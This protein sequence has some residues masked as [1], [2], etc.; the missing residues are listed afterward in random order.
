MK[1]RRVFNQTVLMLLG[2]LCAWTV[3][4]MDGDASVISEPTSEMQD[5][6]SGFTKQVIG[7]LPWPI[8]KIKANYVRDGHVTHR[9]DQMSITL[10]GDVRS[11]NGQVLYNMWDIVTDDKGWEFG[12]K[13]LIYNVNKLLW[14]P[15]RTDVF[16]ISQSR[17]FKAGKKVWIGNKSSTNSS[18][19]SYKTTLTYMK[20]KQYY[21]VASQIKLMPHITTFDS[22]AHSMQ[23]TGTQVGDLIT[24]KFG[25]QVQTARVTHDGHWRIDWGKE[26]QGSGKVTVTETN[27]YDDVPG[28]T[29][30]I[31]N[32]GVPRTKSKIKLNL[33]L[34]GGRNFSTTK[35]QAVLIKGMVVGTDPSD[36]QRDV[37]LNNQDLMIHFAHADGTPIMSYRANGTE[38]EP[39]KAGFFHLKLP[40]EKLQRGIN[41]IKI[42]VT[43]PNDQQSNIDT[44][45][46]TV[47]GGL[48]FEHIVSQIRFT[49]QQIPTKETLIPAM[50]QW[51]VAVK[52]ARSGGS[53]WYVYATATEL[54]TE[55]HRLNGD[56]VYVNS[57][58]KRQIMTNQMT[59]V[60]AC[61]HS[62]GKSVVTDVA[63]QW[64]ERR[65]IF[66][67]VQ[68]GMY[69][70][71][72]HGKINWSLQDTPQA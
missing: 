22:S 3:M 52:D 39:H 48:S 19:E 31:V 29:T 32:N 13:F 34:T 2:G 40:A 33:F 62:K 72:Y 44:L 20:T 15:Q 27:D 16:K 66:L 10:K 71:D 51:Q 43:S 46:V 54:A 42:W 8:T 4:T 41:E 49:S 18:H 26:L 57:A 12:G 68:P 23:G 64:Q 37:K 21:Q 1:L 30:A 35:D 47:A 59:L 60:G 9:T 67:D 5:I 61:T 36:L 14:H 65:G 45:K 70:G 69:A 28:Q 63:Q 24:A 56:L 58:G 55:N 50:N 38:D 53:A 7:E 11:P 6:T 17:R 25:R